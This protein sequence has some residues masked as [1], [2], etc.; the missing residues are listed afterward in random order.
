[1]HATELLD[2]R[3]GA[4]LVVV[5]DGPARAQLDELASGINGRLGR[6]AVALTG[7]LRDPRPAY[8]AADVTLGMGSS[9]LRAM[10]FA[11]P[12]VVLGENGFAEVFAP[13]SAELFLWQGFYGLG[14][15]STTDRAAA[16]LA[17]LVGGLLVDAGLR[18]RL[19]TFGRATVVERFSL[20]RQAAL[21]EGIYRDAQTW[22][23]SAS[24]LAADLARSCAAVLAYKVRHKLA[25]RRGHAAV[26]D[27]NAKSELAARMRVRT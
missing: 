23:P 15:P 26:D 4:S 25:A 27:M 21:L 20:T 14:D 22:R 24:S 9:A 3:F 10:A 6:R 11:R 12:L 1:M 2:A 7:E 17:D 18:D 8:A 19:G 13:D 16:R 5:G